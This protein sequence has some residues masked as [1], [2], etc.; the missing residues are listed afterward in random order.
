MLALQVRPALYNE[1]ITYVG[2]A[3]QARRK[4]SMFILLCCYHVILVRK[5]TLI[6]VS[7]NIVYSDRAQ[8]SRKG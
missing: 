1:T 8:L 4:M 3:N 5:F 6:I 2:S 7:K